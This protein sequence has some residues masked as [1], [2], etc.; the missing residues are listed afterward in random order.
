MV[1]IVRALLSFFVS[2]EESTGEE[3]VDKVKKMNANPRGLLLLL[4]LGLA[5]LSLWS[6]G[7]VPG[8]SGFARAGDLDRAMNAKVAPLEQKVNQVDAKVTEM[9]ASVSELLAL[10]T[11]Q[12]INAKKRSICKTVGSE[13]RSRLNVELNQLL[14]KYLQYTGGVPYAVPSCGDL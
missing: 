1:E 9:S 7:L 6:L 5:A 8:T 10:S 14:A 13:D 2:T 4:A 3:G 11:S 12:N